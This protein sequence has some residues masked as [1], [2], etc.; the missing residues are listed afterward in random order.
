MPSSIETPYEVG[1]TILVEWGNKLHDAKVLA[2]GDGHDGQDVRVHYLR[3]S[4]KWDDWVRFEYTHHITA[5]TRT[6]Q[7]RIAAEFN[8]GTAVTTG[9]AAATH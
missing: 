5:E 6:E 9:E 3:W 2:L 7:A 1:D 4:Q 8:N